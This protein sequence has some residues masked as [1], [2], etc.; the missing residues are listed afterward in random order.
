MDGK[1]TL[2]FFKYER[3]PNFCYWCGRLTHGD[4]ECERWLRSRG[5]LSWEEQ[6]YSAWLRAFVEKPIRRV[7]VKV[8]GRS[9]IPRW[10]ASHHAESGGVRNSNIPSESGWTSATGGKSTSMDFTISS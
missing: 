8:V 3:L 4:R 9:N 6:Q 2:I 7:E 10:G 5:S 1:E